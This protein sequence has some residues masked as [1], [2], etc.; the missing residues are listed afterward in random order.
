M[1]YYSLAGSSVY[2]ILQ[3]RIMEWV[4]FPS[5]EDLPNPG[6]ELFVSFITG[7]FFTT[8]PP[9]KLDICTRITDSLCYTAETNKIL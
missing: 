3:T 1:D 8:E 6:T 4:A 5:A 7:K 2:G 9:G